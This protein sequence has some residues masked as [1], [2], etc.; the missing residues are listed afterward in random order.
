M[1]ER[2]LCLDCRRLRGHAHH[3]VALQFDGDDP[4]KSIALES[5]DQLHARRNA[6]CDGDGKFPASPYSPTYKY[7][8]LKAYI[9]RI[10]SRDIS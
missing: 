10:S 4:R 6:Q 8:G 5:L 9:C 3:L 2:A 7:A 1:D